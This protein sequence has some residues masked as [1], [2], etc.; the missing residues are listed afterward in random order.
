MKELE[1]KAGLIMRDPVGLERDFRIYSKYERYWY[2][3]H[4]R[5]VCSN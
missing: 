3:L 4:F 5:G 2:V 1:R